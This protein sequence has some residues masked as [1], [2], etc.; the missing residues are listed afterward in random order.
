MITIY[1]GWAYFPKHKGKVTGVIF[2]VFGLAT[3]I[4]NSLATYLINPYKLNP[5]IVVPEGK[6][7]LYYFGPCVSDNLPY[8]I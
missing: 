1:C 7:T 2:M 5:S 8:M 3:T 6:N 4:W